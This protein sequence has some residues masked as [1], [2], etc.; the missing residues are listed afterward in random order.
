MRGPATV[1]SGFSR[2]GATATA[3]R[4]DE[5]DQVARD[6]V[7]A[8][9]LDN[10]LID[11]LRTEARRGRRRMAPHAIEP[12]LREAPVH[13]RI[14]QQRDCRLRHAL[15]VV[16]VAEESA[17]AVLD[18]LRQA[19][20]ARGHDRHLARHRFERRQAE[21]LLRRGQQEQIRR[22]TAA[23]RPDP[24]RRELDVAR[25][26]AAR[27]TIRIARPSSGPSPTSISFARTSLRM[28]SK[29]S[30]TASTRLTGLKFER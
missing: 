24:A 23:A 7:I 6:S 11:T 29:I 16:G 9:A 12:R 8:S 27:A 30:T 25:Q 2:T 18:H 19:A 13:D 17:H 4:H 3:G 21:A 26:A 15:E 28:R 1:V 10:F 5:H 14:A 20:D 22:P